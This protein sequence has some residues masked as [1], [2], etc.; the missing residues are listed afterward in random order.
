[1][2]ENVCEEGRM[3]GDNKRM[4]NFRNN[5]PNVQMAKII[6]GGGEHEENGK[7]ERERARESVGT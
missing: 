3:C 4:R 7:R 5:L 1:M 2:L 6:A